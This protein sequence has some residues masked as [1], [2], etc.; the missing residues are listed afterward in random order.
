[1]K[2]IKGYDDWLFIEVTRQPD[3]EDHNDGMRELA[4]DED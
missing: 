1:M 4:M 3:D 2:M